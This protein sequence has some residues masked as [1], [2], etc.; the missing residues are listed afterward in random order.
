MSKKK[1]LPH[2]ATPIG[3]FFPEISSVTEG[4]G[5]PVAKFVPLSVS[6]SCSELT[7]QAN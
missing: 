6:S 3:L 4:Y 2:T 7:K 1:T 5:I